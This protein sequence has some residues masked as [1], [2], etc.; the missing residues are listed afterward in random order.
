MDCKKL[1]HLSFHLISR[2]SNLFFKDLWRWESPH[3][4]ISYFLIFPFFFSALSFKPINLSL[5]KGNPVWIGFF[6]SF[7]L[8]GA[9][10]FCSA[11]PHIIYFLMFLFGVLSTASLLG[12]LLPQSV[13]LS[14]GQ[15]LL[16]LN[17]LERLPLCFCSDCTL[18]YSAFLFQSRVARMTC[19]WNSKDSLC[20]F[21]AEPSQCFLPPV[22]FFSRRV[23]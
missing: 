9:T 8:R 10:P 4:V 2:L 3:R 16:D 19:S 1:S 17:N 23:M 18:C 12:P 13:V 7:L 20:V 6:F 21:S 22:C 5:E 14:T 11:F 15:W